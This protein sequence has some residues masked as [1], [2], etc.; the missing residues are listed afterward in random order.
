M[1]KLIAFFLVMLIGCGILVGIMAGGGGVTTTVLAEN[2]TANATA[3][4]VTN[5]TNFLD[6]D[7]VIIQ[8]EKVFYTGTTPTSFTGCTRGYDDTTASAHEEGVQVYTATASGLNYALGFNIVAV[9][10]ELGWAAIIAIPLMFFVRTIPQIVRMST[11]LLTG[12]LAIISWFFY[13]IIAAFIVTLAM[14]L[15]GS[16][17]VT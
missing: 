14:T 15:I 8:S 12:D 13:A 7:Y 17:R 1:N 3:L 10:D 9:Q 4:V 5:T 6:E 16:R 11:T 2:V